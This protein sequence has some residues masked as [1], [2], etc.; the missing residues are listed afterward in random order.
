METADYPVCLNLIARVMPRERVDLLPTGCD[1]QASP[2]I[3][4]ASNER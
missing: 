3:P 4:Y 1:Y 2:G